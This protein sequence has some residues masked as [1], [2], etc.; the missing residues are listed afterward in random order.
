MLHYCNILHSKLR[1]VLA[2]T[3]KVC[4]YEKWNHLYYLNNWNCSGALRSYFYA[5]FYY[6]TAGSYTTTTT[7][8]NTFYSS[9]FSSRA[10][11]CKEKLKMT[12]E[13]FLFLF[14]LLLV[15]VIILLYM[16]FNYYCYSWK[17]EIVI[18]WWWV[19][20]QKLKDE[21]VSFCII[22]HASLYAYQALLMIKLNLSQYY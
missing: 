21:S 3:I 2:Y 16:L 6:Y 17:L 5:F 9:S 20:R 22:K 19:K 4:C 15:V 10:K 11:K 18:I 7:Y 12:W 13:K 8:I 14:C 1:P